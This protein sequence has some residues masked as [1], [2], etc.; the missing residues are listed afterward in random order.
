MLSHENEYEI[1]T[2]SSTAHSHAD[3]PWYPLQT[4]IQDVIA[5]GRLIIVG[6]VHGRLPELKKLVE[7]VAYSKPNGDKLILVGDLINKG[8][9][10]PGVVSLAME[11]GASA[12]RGNNEDRVLAAHSAIKRGEDTKLVERLK[13]LA[14]KAEKENDKKDGEPAPS[15]T[16]DDL[17]SISPEDLKPYSS[18]SD[19]TTAANLSDE[20]ISWLASQ[21]LVLR[22]KLR[23]GATSPPWN[24]GTLL[25]AHGGLVPLLP[26]EEQDSWAVMNMRGLVYPD[27]EATV[28][29]PIRAGLLKGAKSRTRR[30]AAY[31]DV[32]D[33]DIKTELS[34]W[35]DIVNNGKGFSGQYKEGVIGFP[36]ETREGDWWIDAW[37]R[38]QNSIGDPEKRSIVVYGH[39]ARVG[40]Q[41]GADSPEVARYTFGLDSGCVYG[42]SLTAMIIDEKEDGK[43][44]SHS[45][46]QVDA[47]KK[48]EGKEGEAV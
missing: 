13:R 3:F 11:L 30:Y 33:A 27:P 45:I 20:Q 41:V 31:G 21:P 26:L 9:D 37:N 18:E 47:I 14:L 25:V 40:I 32:N 44:L 4:R 12:I 22:I 35:A 39:D 48:D 8:P 2:H 24:S 38:W 7:K 15:E 46:V 16:K 29:E 28:T 17:K 1:N 42:K 36:L 6:D 43:G 23:K 34:K 5:P 10:S 19:F